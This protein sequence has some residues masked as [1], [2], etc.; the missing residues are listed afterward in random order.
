MR[1]TLLPRMTKPV[2]FAWLMCLS[3]LLAVLPA[4]AKRWM[5]ACFQ[6]TAW[7]EWL[8]ST[9][10]RSIAGV[11]E[12]LTA[13]AP[14]TLDAGRL[15][16]ENTELRRQLSQQE[17]Q[18]DS[19]RR[20]LDE[21]TALRGQLTDSRSRIVIA[22]VLSGPASPRR[23]ELN[24]SRGQSSGIR[25]GDWVVAGVPPDRAATLSGRELAARCWLI[26]T[27]VDAQYYESRVRLSSD[28]AF[29]PHRVAFAALTDSGRWAL[30]DQEALLSGS[31]DG[32]IARGVPRNLFAQGYTHALVSLASTPPMPMLLGELTSAQPLASSPLHFDF[33]VRPIA[34][35]RTLSTV[36]VISLHAEP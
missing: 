23:Q 9:S 32:M 28:A 13:D 24:L 5:A 4:G 7:A 17:L 2:L 31:G 1:W 8:S 6:L 36:Y 26:G 20:A 34:D 10:A 14:S 35:V 16:E 3:A 22:T 27:I 21:V 33:R 11:G 15:A 30:S 19:L 18:L 25:V 12:A 29:G